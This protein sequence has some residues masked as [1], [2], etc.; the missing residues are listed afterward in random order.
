MEEVRLKRI[1]IVSS[2]FD[3]LHAG[4]VLLLKEARE[5]CDYLIAALHTDPTIERPNTKDRPTQSTL[6]RFL[7]LQ[8]CKYVDEIVPYDTEEDLKNLMLIKNVT[9]IFL[10]SEYENTPYTGHDLYL[11]VT[12]HPRKHTYSSTRLRKKLKNY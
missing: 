1:G 11:N 5:N 7:Q 10:G 3:L 2:A 4:H 12:F 8:G 6:E 9:H